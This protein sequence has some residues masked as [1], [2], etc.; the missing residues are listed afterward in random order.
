MK[1]VIAAA[2]LM[3]SSGIALAQDVTLDVVGSLSTSSLYPTYEVPFWTETLPAASDGRI[4]VSLQAFDRIG[5]GGAAVYEMVEQGVYD[6]GTT[7]IDY[8]AGDEPRVEG[9]DIP[10]IAD[11]ALTH[12]IA[13][14]Y[15]P[16]LEKVFAEAYDSVLLGVAPFTAQVVFCKAEINGLDDLAGLRIRGSGRMTMD[17]IEAVGGTGVSIAFNEVPVALDRGVID[18]GITGTLSGFFGGWS[19]VSTHFYPLPIGGWDPVGIAI[20]SDTWNSLDKEIQTLLREQ[21]ASLEDR[22]WENAV[23]DNQIGINCNTGGECPVGKALNLTLVEI[24][25]EDQRRAVELTRGTVLPRWHDRCPGVCA[26]TFTE[27]VGPLLEAA[28]NQ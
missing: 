15:R 19:E 3:G 23:A 6:V 9:L 18:C 1:P 5:L 7:I 26:E 24:T 10:A 12:Q 8:V 25:P 4:A 20:N 22:I 28:L 27:T 14:A 17:F 16:Y 2:L 13:N 11:P 21:V